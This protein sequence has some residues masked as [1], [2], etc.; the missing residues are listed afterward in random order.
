MRYLCYF[1]LCCLP[2]L[3][4]TVNLEAGWK[5][6]GAEKSITNMRNFN[7]DCVDVV[8]VYD[9]FTK[10]WQEYFLREEN[11]A[12]KVVRIN[13]GDGFWV[14]ATKSCSFDL[15]ANPKVWAKASTNE[16]M[17]ENLNAAIKEFYDLYWDKGATP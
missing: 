11:R 15:Q 16:P 4:Q 5:L 2:I 17:T 7:K 3:A 1:C 13:E 6:L 14:H 9:R 10:K 8:L 12:K